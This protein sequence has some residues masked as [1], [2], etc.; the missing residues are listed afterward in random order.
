MQNILSLLTIYNPYITLL[1]L[2]SCL[3]LIGTSTILMIKL[4]HFMKGQNG[5][6]LEPIIRDYINQIEDLK[7][8][9][10]KLAQHALSLEER[11]KQSIRNVSTLRFKAFEAGASNQSFAIALLNEHGDG[12]MLS[13]LHH[14]D[15]ASFFAKPIKGYK[16]EH[17]LTEEEEQVLHDT[18][19]ANKKHNN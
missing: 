6:S 5:Q 15:R 8:H 13:S 4:S 9:D 1:L 2:G 16:S 10:E 7:K 3:I 14:R 11:T 18:R 19:E 12:V 17:E